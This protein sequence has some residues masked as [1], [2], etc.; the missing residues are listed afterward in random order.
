MK[1]GSWTS[2]L[3]DLRAAAW[4]A[5]VLG[6]LVYVNSIPNGFAYD[7][8]HILV[9][10]ERIHTLDRFSEALTT[11]YW[12]IEDGQAL[13]LWRPVATGTYALIWNAFDGSPLPFHVVNVLLH[14]LV[15]GL[16]TLLLGA[17]VPVGAAFAGGALFAV[18]PLHTEVVANVVGF[19]EIVGALAMV[20]ACLLFLRWRGSGLGPGRSAVIAG[21]F[22]LGLL[23]KESAIT[24][25]GVLLLL[26]GYLDDLRLGDLRR[27]LRERWVLYA[28][29]VAAAAVVFL[30]RHAV[31]GS[32]ADP[33]P[34]LGAELLLEIPRIWTLGEI[35]THYVRL[36]FVPY[37]LSPEYSP[38]VI[39]IHL[40]W[41]L[42]NSLGAVLVLAFLA[43][44]LL[45]W[46]RWRPD[47]LSARAVGAGVLWFVI[48]MSPVSNFFFLSG[49]LLGERTL[50]TPS[51]GFCLAAGW[52][53]WALARRRAQ[54]AWAGL[55][56]VVLLMSVRTVTRNPVWKD[57]ETVFTNLLDTHLEAGR[58]QWIMGDT[59]WEKNQVSAALK[60]Y[61]YAIGSVGAG[62][63]LISEITK[64]LLG[65]ER[66]AQAETLAR[67]LWKDEPTW[68]AG[69]GLLT[70]ALIGQ[71]R[72]EEAVTSGIVA[73]D[74]DPDDAVTRH[75]LSDALAKAGRTEEAIVERRAAIELGEREHW[76][77]WLWLAQLQSQAGEPN[78]ARMSI[79]SA[80][81]R[82]ETPEALQALD[83]LAAGL[84]VPGRDVG[85][86][87][88]GEGPSPATLRDR[89]VGAAES[90]LR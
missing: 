30:G 88:G 8:L 66:W 77:Q 73:R 70:V 55:A 40:G 60:S 49:T 27:Y 57:T 14:G 61:R 48:T 87:E 39:A 44:G 53:F 26:D 13:G 89:R 16:V 28:S 18:H 69:P 76:Q 31:L 6:A 83:S 64:K 1:R 82:A 74:L 56:V 59:F 72:Y 45:S 52:A 22:A 51:I 17:L 71:E 12:P 32:L 78:D 41:N 84:T 79:D 3:T 42:V 23:T 63:S 21:V 37:D 47:G 68:D 11:P 35:W 58:A 36:L 38:G 54:L 81:A 46:R 24:L 10:N 34:P 86:G 67:M 15:T 5:A 85:G 90:L 65:L 75:L 62:Y 4:V 2:P 19:A 20:G 33:L 7:D 25:P 9:D 80:R 43:I 29:I 50:Y